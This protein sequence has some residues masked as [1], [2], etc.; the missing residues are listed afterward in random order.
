MLLPAATCFV[1]VRLAEQLA[2]GLTGAGRVTLSEETALRCVGV[3]SAIGLLIPE[4]DEVGY[5]K[6]AR[7]LL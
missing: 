7:R 1:Y 4:A 3:C 6:A 2:W 5:G